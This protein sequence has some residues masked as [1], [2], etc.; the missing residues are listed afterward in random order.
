MFYQLLIYS[1]YLVHSTKQLWNKQMTGQ[2]SRSKGQ[3]PRALEFISSRK[4]NV[5]A[6]VFRAEPTVYQAVQGRADGLPYSACWR[7]IP[8]LDQS[9]G[10]AQPSRLLQN[11][12]D[13]EKTSST[14]AKDA[15]PQARSLSVDWIQSLPGGLTLSG[16][17]LG[18]S[19]QD[20]S[21]FKYCTW[22]GFW[23]FE[24]HDL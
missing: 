2:Y 9:P 12:K 5:Y 22:N 7:S 17:F 23:K 18:L 19:H 6:S 11:D 20:D 4:E 14:V 21:A 15:N 13:P 8:T 10:P 1:S 24:I 3:K 16:R